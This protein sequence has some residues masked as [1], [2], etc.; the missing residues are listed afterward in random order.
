MGPLEERAGGDE[1]GWE[2][3]GTSCSKNKYLK[4]SAT[5]GAT[6]TGSLDTDEAIHAAAALLS[7]QK[8]DKKGNNITCRKAGGVQTKNKQKKNPTKQPLYHQLAVIKPERGRLPRRQACAPSAGPLTF[9]R[10]SQAAGALA[11]TNPI[12]CTW[13]GGGGGVRGGPLITQRNVAE[14]GRGLN[15]RRP[16]GLEDETTTRGAPLR[17]GISWK[18]T[19]GPFYSEAAY[20]ISKK[21]N[22]RG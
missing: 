19:S 16:G 14:G 10:V 17:P 20:C 1:G 6:V 13:G 9:Q 11:V 22:E 8:K 18:C 2:R 21:N 4:S 15:P 12:D 3:G 7:S 5:A